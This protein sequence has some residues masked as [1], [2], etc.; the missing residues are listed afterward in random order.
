MKRLFLAVLSFFSVITYAGSN[1]LN[2][3][4]WSNYI[5]TKVIR[6]FEK[7]TG[8]KVYYSTFENNEAL[9]AKLKS[10]PNSGYD[11]IF[12]STY[13]VQRMA[14]EGLLE[15]LKLSRLSN[16][17]YL[18]PRL[19]NL[20][21]DPHN[22]YTIPYLW[23]TVSILVNDRYYNPK[24]IHE[25]SDLWQP[26]FKGQL[27]IL[28]DVRD[29]FSVALRVLGYSINDRDPKHIYQAYVLLKKL[30]PNIRLFN[31]DGILPIY[32][33]GDA[34][35]G[36]IYSGDGY[37]LHNTDPR[38]QFIYPKNQVIMTMDCMAIPKGAPHLNNAYRFINFV[39]QPKISAM[40]SEGIGYST[41]NLAAVKLMP[42]ADQE[43]RIMNP[44]A[45]VLDGA[46]MESDVGDKATAV[47]MHY[48]EMLK[49]SA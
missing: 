45:N 47:Y 25:W 13:Y 3:Y 34:T 39:M 7:E 24:S 16:F 40:I 15:P 19:L 22:R 4:N 9:Y 36:M 26:R 8:I 23:S 42:K 1:V 41:P 43:S 28:D 35:V 38:L 12:P 33:D 21:Y 17:N 31:Q 10:A 2:I 30:L 11:L 32:L 18:N 6:L 48:W 49:L 27:L 37:V 5:P 14:D 46:Q 20:E 29:T 44:P